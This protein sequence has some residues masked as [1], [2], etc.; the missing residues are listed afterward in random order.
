[1]K[2]LTSITR[3]KTIRLLLTGAVLS[4]LVLAIFAVAEHS[5]ASS[6]EET[7]RKAI[8]PAADE[9]LP[10]QIDV[11]GGT[12]RG[13]NTRSLTT[14]QA[15]SLT[16]L[17]NAVGVNLN[18]RYN[19]LTA[20]PMFI[21]NPSGYLTAPSAAPAE[22]I[23]RDF[24]SSW[25]E[26]FRF[27]QNNLNSLKLQSRAVSPEGITV[28][29][30]QQQANGI[31]VYHG[32]VL[33]NVNKAGQIMTVGGDSFPR[34]QVTNSA[35]I[36]QATAVSN[37]ASSLGVSG[38][39][40]Q[41]LGT[42]RILTT[43]GDLSPEYANGQKFAHSVFTDDIEVQTV[44]FPLGD[45]GRIAYKFNLTSALYHNIIWMNIVDAQT[46]E[47][48]KR[49]SLTSYF[50]EPGG[51]T[52]I[53]RKGTFRPDVQNMIE[54]NNAG[55]TARGKVFDTMP[56]TLSKVG[57]T[58][59]AVRS[60]TAGSYM[61]TNP[62]YDLEA[63]T[64]LP[65]RYSIVAARNENPLPFTNALT[66][67]PQLLTAS[68]LGQVTRG[69]PDAAN[70]NPSSPFGW[71]YLPTNSNGTEITQ[72]NA[73]TAPTRVVGYTM[74]AE[75][76]TRNLPA[77]S[78]NGNGSQTFSADLTTLGSPVTL[79][80]GR[81]LS[82]VYQSRYTEG[83][84]VSV[85][86]DREN[87][88]DGTKGIKGYS[89]NRQFSASYFDY[90]ASYEFGNVDASGGGT[91]STTPV[92]YPASSNADVYAD[93]TNLFFFNN[94]EHDYLYSIG[95]TEP[96][97]NFQFDNFGKGG[98]GGDA[99]IAEVQDGSGTDNANMGTPAEG[100]NPR[101]QMYLFTDGGFRRSDGDLDWD[102]VA[103][104]H[105]HGVSNR[106]AAKGGDSCLGTPLVGESGGMGEGWSDAIAS[107]MSD[108]DSE[109]EY[110]TGQFDNAIRRLPY[111]NYRYSYGSI[112]DVTLNV[113]QAGSAIALPDGNVGGI[114]YEVHD[115]GEV[116]AA[117]L[118]DMRELM[119][120]KQKVNNSYPGIFFDGA[121]RTGTGTSFYIGD[122]QVQSVDANHPIDYRQ[123][124]LTD[125]GGA[126]AHVG[127][128]APTLNATRGDITRPGALAT[129]NA[130][131][132]QRNGPL[133]TAVARGA[134]LADTIILR[135]L[136]L[137]VCNPTFVDMRDSMLAADRE[138]TGGENQAIIKRSFAS[139]GVGVNATSSGKTNGTGQQGGP[140]VIVE[141]FTVSPDVT[142]C[143][144]LGPLTAPTFTLA[145][146]AA[147]AVT[148]TIAPVAGATSYVIARSTSANGPF[149]TLATQAGT[150]FNDNDG[151]NGLVV[152]QTYYYQ[153][154]AARN[155]SCVGVGNI[156]S[157]TI[158][159]GAA[160][161]PAPMFA[162]LGKINDP[163][164]GTS[165][166]LSWSPASSTNQ[167]ANIVYD[168][169]RVIN[170]AADT[171]LV[172]PTFVP[173][174]ANRIAQGVTGTSYTDGN[175]MLGQQ[176]YYIVQARDT[177]NGKIDTLGVGNT[178][179]QLNAP[180]SNRVSAMAP[181]TL[182]TFE[183]TAASARF[184]PALTESAA[185]DRSM[186]VFERTVGDLGAGTTGLSE[187]GD[188]TADATNAATGLMYAGDY[189]PANSGM[190]GP[191]DF[192]V[193]IQPTLALLNR[194]SFLEFDHR[195][196]T[197]ATFDG[198]NI[199]I[200]LGAPLLVTP[201]PNNST[202]FDLNDYIV[203]NP[204]NGTLNGTLEGAA[205]GSP[206]LGRRSFTGSRP[207]SHVRV[208]IG[209]FRAGG[210]KNPNGSPVY[211]RFHSTSDAG[212]FVDGWYVDNVVVRNF[213]AAVNIESDVQPRPSGDG[214]V[215]A[216]DIQEIRRFAVGL[217]APFQTTEFQRADGSPRALLG[218]GYLDAD[219]V[220]QARRYAVGTDTNQAT[221]GPATAAKSA[222]NAKTGG[223]LTAQQSNRIREIT[224]DN[225]LSNNPTRTTPA[226]RVDNQTIGAG[227]TIT[228]PV[229]VDATGSEAGYTFGLSYDPAKL[230]NP[231]VSIGKAGG[232][233]VSNVNNPGQIGFSVTS[234]SGGKIAANT[235]QVLVN[236]QFTVANDAPAGITSIA[237]N[238]ELTRQKAAGV[239]PSVP[240][241]QPI[242]TDGTLTINP[243]SS[244]TSSLTGRVMNENGT[245]LSRVAMTISNA[246]G[247]T[248]TMLT[249]AF[250]YFTFSDLAAGET[251]L[252]AAKAKGYTFNPSSQT[253]I[254]NGNLAKI[255]FVGR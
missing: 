32:E 6:A 33:V 219:D 76:Q 26:A 22:Q 203:E 173:T 140:A 59:R 101:M 42:A 235:N 254:V 232:D 96:F 27:D 67:V 11:R 118:W 1:M 45:T 240:I 77:N 127:S 244:E 150:T 46:G 202:T 82:S 138:I 165:L 89:A 141:D 40:A 106:S 178:V 116:W 103:H 13:L 209:D 128:A 238:S 98:A 134:R 146:S 148:V 5:R 50:G 174:A 39:A 69:F 230:T 212:S 181:F 43:Y 97:W 185:P 58:G 23:A 88:N 94:V 198:G 162:G 29:L 24:I 239:D 122:R 125:N 113:R 234:F 195:F 123:T 9:N 143:E 70:P 74:A 164:T 243:V 85:S 73:T 170:V 207:L 172:A 81:V 227:Q 12:P 144:T 147:N 61:V 229:R 129:E 119:I 131:N 44:V 99:I 10:A 176:Y 214:V 110:V 34:M 142:A 183:T 4:A 120:V 30:F 250:G 242:Y 71:F 199:E 220:Q 189:D 136:Q 161:S 151:G 190:G 79:P 163:R 224:G 7:N 187:K 137:A 35:V 124:F 84:N 251:Y 121:K 90:L 211:I 248:R 216:D 157:V 65:F 246:K 145:N 68:L 105:Y 92:V 193:T 114:P 188:E 249:N 60:G 95:F 87:D 237:F 49:T 52:T 253:I 17:Q 166:L 184:T 80:D 194:T 14:V 191:S 210:I 54:G 53:P 218:D 31:P 236:V 153:V 155:T 83:N 135:G 112:N 159:I 41:S 57:G 201:S 117:M 107:S 93:T 100:A 171:D 168:I 152:G 130:S 16:S 56:T 223:R 115:V 72:G 158:T 139:H 78:P 25:R 108:D 252:I 38:F 200:T 91:G 102:V 55:G 86:D 228:V 222:G 132:P 160:L 208:A 225:S 133:A 63:T 206:L 75:A 64:T 233:V 175:L 21:S 111:T 20:T 213:D 126:G 62:V 217:D 19:G 180:T 149:T 37:A 182:E 104:E 215:D 169:Y 179:T 186:P 28:L 18:V 2:K 167:G 197:E 154:H 156:N 221:G 48:L 15:R 36:D 3:H 205:M 47:I 192:A 177:T 196:A 231:V 66:Q 247:E 109:G 245:S 204:Y 226:F 51:G 255:E 8:S 241:V